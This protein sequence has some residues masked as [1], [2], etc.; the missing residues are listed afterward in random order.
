VDAELPANGI[1]L[2]L[3]HLCSSIHAPAKNSDIT[4][5]VVIVYQALAFYKSSKPVVKSETNLRPVQNLLAH[6]DLGLAF[7]H[8]GID[9]VRT[10]ILNIVDKATTGVAADFIISFSGVAAASQEQRTPQ[11]KSPVGALA[12]ITVQSLQSF[13][14]ACEVQD[15]L[16]RLLQRFVKRVVG[17]KTD[18]HSSTLAS[19]LSTWP[20]NGARNFLQILCQNNFRRKEDEKMQCTGA[21][22]IADFLQTICK[23]LAMLPFSKADSIFLKDDF[24]MAIKCCG[25]DDIG[26]RIRPIVEEHLSKKNTCHALSLLNLLSSEDSQTQREMCTPLVVRAMNAMP[27]PPEPLWSNKTLCTLLVLIANLEETAGEAWS[28]A[29]NDSNGNA[30]PKAT[31]LMKTMLCTLSFDDIV[32]LLNEAEILFSTNTLKSRRAAT[33]ME[34]IASIE[35]E[36]AKKRKRVSPTPPQ[37]SWKVTGGPFDYSVF[38]SNPC[39]RSLVLTCPKSNHVKLRREFHYLIG[40]GY[41]DVNFFQ[42]HGRGK[43]CR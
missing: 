20:A 18:Q 11:K 43:F 34:Q 5:F 26:Q 16:V 29:W 12:D 38:L 23:T 13:A 3:R 8:C 24:E 30:S 27:Q 40:A 6:A 19:N 33:V 14:S 36:K 42:Y 9:E 21:K 31:E 39:R 4:E 22:D 17:Y 35:L 41:V 2:I 1:G 10:M 28:A 7:K 25:F 37:T 32:P 15:M